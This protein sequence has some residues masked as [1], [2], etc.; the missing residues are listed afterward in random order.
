MKP[1]EI[2]KMSTAERLQTMEMLWESLLDDET[3][4]P[5]PEW[6]GEILAERKRKIEENQAEFVSL[7]EVKAR[8]DG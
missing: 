8:R 6:H 7:D 2:K 5:S 4:L 3:G 1:A